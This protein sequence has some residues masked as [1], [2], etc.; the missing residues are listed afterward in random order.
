MAHEKSSAKSSAKVAIARSSFIQ[1]YSQAK[2]DDERLNVSRDYIST[3]EQH[4]CKQLGDYQRSYQVSL[5][6]IVG[7]Y[8]ID[9]NIGM[10]SRHAYQHIR[11]LHRDSQRAQD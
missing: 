9:V 2:T 7:V 5:L 6:S 11:R 8:V 10:V 3:H 1:Q 4:T